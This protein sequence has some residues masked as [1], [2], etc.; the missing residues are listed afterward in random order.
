VQVAFVADAVGYDDALV[1]PDLALL[2]SRLY[3]RRARFDPTLACWRRDV[4]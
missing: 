1:Y 3:L 4:N 2:Q